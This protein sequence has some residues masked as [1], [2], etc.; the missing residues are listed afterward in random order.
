MFLRGVLMTFICKFETYLWK[1][2]KVS[3]VT[4]VNKDNGKADVPTKM[5]A[6]C[7]YIE[8]NV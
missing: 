6:T 4:H 5:S 1:R 7:T 2:L 3:T 8:E